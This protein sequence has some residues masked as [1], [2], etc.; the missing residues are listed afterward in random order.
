[1]QNV[2]QRDPVTGKPRYGEKTINRVK[3]VIRTYKAL[4]LGVSI[5]F[6]DTNSSKGEY[7][8]NIT[9][10]A[11]IVSI[12]RSQVQQ[13]NEQIRAQTQAFQSNQ[14]L[15]SDR[16][17]KERLLAEE[18]AKEQ[19]LLDE[20]LKREQEKELAQRAQEARRRRVE[21]EQRALEA[22]CE[23]DRELMALVPIKGAEGVRM[24]IGRMPCCWCCRD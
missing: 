10:T 23:S 14:Q 1:M 9:D 5:A 6:Q 8:S 16:L 21:E 13:H 3:N 4:E 20:Q 24:Q 17:S 11:C 7:S 19:R 18:R 12:L 15:E 22:E 2:N